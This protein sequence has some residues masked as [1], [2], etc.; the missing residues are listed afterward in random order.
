MVLFYNPYVHYQRT[1]V[2]TRFKILF[3][4][5]HVY[6]ICSQTIRMQGLIRTITY[7][8]YILN[9][10]LILYLTLVIP[11][12]QYASTVWKSIR[13]TDAKKLE[14][15]QRKFV[16]L[17]QNCFFTYDHVTYEDFPKIMNLHTLHNRRLNYWCSVLYFRI[18]RFNM[19]PVSFGC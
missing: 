16:D 15:S 17:C 11:Q 4:R 19:L 8:V 14:R 6:Y 10:L 13:F 2:T 9:N 1:W 12:L 5:A 7:S 3:P 18:F